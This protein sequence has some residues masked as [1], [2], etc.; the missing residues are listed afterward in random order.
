M[1][2][3][4]TN[5]TA[6]INAL[7]VT[8]DTDLDSL[9]TSLAAYMDALE[10]NTTDFQQQINAARGGVKAT[11]SDP[12]HGSPLN[13]ISSV[14]G[15]YTRLSKIFGQGTTFASLAARHPA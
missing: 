7:A 6:T 1:A 10:T 4:Y 14:T 2:I 5:S 13:N 9:E 3:N 15:K 12:L 11:S 8:L